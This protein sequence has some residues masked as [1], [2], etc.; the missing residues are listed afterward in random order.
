[1]N[2]ANNHLWMGAGVAGFPLGAAAEIM[3]EE[4]RDQLSGE[5]SLERVVFALWSKEA[6]RAFVGGVATGEAAG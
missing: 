2:A 5:A 1:M 6:Y 3:V 4:V